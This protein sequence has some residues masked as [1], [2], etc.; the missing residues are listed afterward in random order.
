[1]R[2]KF[3]CHC[4]RQ[5]QCQRQCHCRRQYCHVQVT[6]V[7]CST[8]PP[9][10]HHRPPRLLILRIPC[11][12]PPFVSHPDVAAAAVRVSTT[13]T[14]HVCK[15]GPGQLLAPTRLRPLRLACVPAPGARASDLEAVAP[16][17]RWRLAARASPCLPLEP[18]QGGPECELKA[19]SSGPQIRS[20]PRSCGRTSVSTAWRALVSPLGQRTLPKS[21]GP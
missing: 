6:L 21:P 13:W 2:L 9:A 14:A 16:A 5:C 18:P 12:R 4:Q 7:F 17:T 10:L 8:D 19:F 20:L 11:P 15:R 1:M 3:K